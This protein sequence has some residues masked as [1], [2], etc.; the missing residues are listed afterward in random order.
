MTKVI[1]LEIEINEHKEH[2]ETAVIDL[3]KTDIFLE[4]NWLIKHNSKVNWKEGRI[5]FTQYLGSCKMEH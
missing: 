4:H 1:S 5:Q 2:I 3:N